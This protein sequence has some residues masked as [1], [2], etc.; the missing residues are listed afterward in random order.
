VHDSKE[1]ESLSVS[2]Q[3]AIMGRTKSD[4]TELDPKPEDSHVARSDQDTFG[5]MIFRRNM[6]YGTV[7]SHGT[8]F[9]GFSSDQHRL[10]A[11]LESMAG[12]RDGVRD[13]LTYFTK[14][15]TGAYYFIPPLAALR[16]IG[17]NE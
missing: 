16:L 9:V 7:T 5:K 2:R 15:L 10:V 4:S 3:E 11:M 17:G 13:A 12:V 14:P 6:P 1:W 8:M